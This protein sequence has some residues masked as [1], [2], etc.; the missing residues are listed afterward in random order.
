ML[1]SV[2]AVMMLG[3]LAGGCGEDESPQDY[4]PQGYCDDVKSWRSSWVAFEEEV[5]TLVNNVRV[6]GYNCDTEGNFGAAPAV[7]LDSVLRCSARKH[8]RDM[9]RREFFA[10]ENLDGESPTDRMV[11]AGFTNW[12][13]TGENIAGGQEDPDTVM[14]AWLESDGHCRNIMDPD[15]TRLGIGYYFDASTDYKQF[16]TQNFGALFGD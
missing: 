12:Q 8:S 11:K 10:H 3:L 4:Q 2:V 15:F 5:L 13:A 9:A 16:W 7:E 6:V 1:R 14:A